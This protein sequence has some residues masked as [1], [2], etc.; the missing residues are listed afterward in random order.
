MTILPP[1]DGTTTFTLN[2]EN[3]IGMTPYP[4]DI[5]TSNTPPITVNVFYSGFEESLS[6]TGN[7]LATDINSG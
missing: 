2:V 4:A 5:V 1:N 7:V 6:I 3:D